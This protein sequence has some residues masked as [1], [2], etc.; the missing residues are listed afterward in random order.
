MIVRTVSRGLF[1][2]NL[3]GYVADAARRAN[4]GEVGTVTYIVA[5]FA[6]ATAGATAAA[7]E[8][9]W[10]GRWIAER[11]KLPS[12]GERARV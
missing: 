4:L 8:R 2:A 9:A 6:R 11:L 3:A 5:E 12:A 1:L 7:S 10:Q